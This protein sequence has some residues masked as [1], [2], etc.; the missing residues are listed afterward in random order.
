MSAVQL[1][2]DMGQLSISGLGSVDTILEVLS[3]DNVAHTTLVQMA[4]FGG[5][6]NTSGR[7]TNEAPDLLR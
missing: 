1:V 4:A 6:F 7:Y 5:L 2:A 3:E